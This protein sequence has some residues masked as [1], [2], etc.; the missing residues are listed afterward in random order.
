MID[1]R[2]RARCIP[3]DDAAFVV[4]VDA[5]LGRLASKSDR[6]VVPALQNRVRDRY[7]EATIVAQDELASLSPG[8]ELVYVYRDGNHA[9]T[10]NNGG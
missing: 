8:L 3:N 2:R 1:H 5:A 9:D 4:F 7:P 6:D 10:S